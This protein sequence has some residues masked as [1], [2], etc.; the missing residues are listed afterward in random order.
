MPYRLVLVPTVVLLVISSVALG[1][2][3]L[4]EL[5]VTAVL[6]AEPAA[7]RRYLVAL[8]EDDAREW[9][10]LDASLSPVADRESV[11]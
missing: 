3:S 6:P 2:P 7:Q 11:R 8:G 9:L 4:S 1:L 5:T 10:V